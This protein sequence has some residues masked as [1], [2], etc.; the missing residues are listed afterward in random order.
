M[1]IQNEADYTYY[2]TKYLLRNFPQK[3]FVIDAGA[4]QMMDPE[5]L[6]KLKTALAREKLKEI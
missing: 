1:K 5:W 2:L 4:L 3:K 6:K